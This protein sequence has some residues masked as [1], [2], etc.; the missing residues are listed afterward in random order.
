M[1]YSHAPLS[2]GHLHSAMVLGKDILLAISLTT[3]V[4]L[5]GYISV[6]NSG[7]QEN[8][9]VQSEKLKAH[10]PPVQLNIIQ[11]PVYK[12]PDAF[13]KRN[14]PIQQ[15]W[16]APQNT[17]KPSVSANPSGVRTPSPAEIMAA[18]TAKTSQKNRGLRETKLLTVDSMGDG[19][20]SYKKKE[21]VKS[22][23]PFEEALLNKL[24]S[25][26][27]GQSGDIKVISTVEESDNPQISNPD[28]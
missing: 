26:K 24:Q 20:A 19:E 16:Q 2:R 21:F 17:F 15:Q 13:Y 27:T 22:I 5:L 1:L 11:A 12:Q 9:P 23:S 14:E 28:S 25:R 7:Q 3:N 10:G 4:A 18:V 8:V 6:G